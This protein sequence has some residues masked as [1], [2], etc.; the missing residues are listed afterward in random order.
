MDGDCPRRH[1]HNEMKGALVDNR[2]A[3]A[4]TGKTPDS[5]MA[6]SVT[7][8]AFGLAMLSLFAVLAFANVV[9]LGD[10]A[11]FFALPVLLFTVSGLLFL[12]WMQGEAHEAAVQEAA[13]RSSMRPVARG[14]VVP[15]RVEPRRQVRKSPEAARR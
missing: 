5:D 4:S 8:I 11:P 2:G 3:R 13:H 10:V 9:A 7:A 14:R 6:L 15:A 12:H 1:P